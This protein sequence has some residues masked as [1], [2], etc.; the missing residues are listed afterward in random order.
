MVCPHERD[1]L[2]LGSRAV[3][4]CTDVRIPAALIFHDTRGKIYAIFAALQLSHAALQNNKNDATGGIKDN[5]R[6]DG[7]GTSPA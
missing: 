2:R 3:P 1:L 5:D 7:T 6:L 4:A